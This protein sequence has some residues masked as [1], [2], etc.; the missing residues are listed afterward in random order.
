MSNLEKKG[1]QWLSCHALV[2]LAISWTYSKSFLF[3]AV[4]YTK[5]K[6][7][8]GCNCTLVY[9]KNSPL[10]GLILV[11]TFIDFVK[12]IPPARLLCPAR[13]LFFINFST[14]TFISSYTSIRYTRVQEVPKSTVTT[15][16][17]LLSYIRHEHF[18]DGF[19]FE[20]KQ[21][22]TLFK[23]DSLWNIECMN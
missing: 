7:G 9:R 13:L 17:H 6:F 1:G 21:L 16:P 22:H 18:I 23:K 4:F 12:K 5:T 20:E 11:C 8:Q 15:V 3:K 19:T 14:C 10:H 2:T